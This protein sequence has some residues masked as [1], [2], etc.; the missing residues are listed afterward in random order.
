MSDRSSPRYVSYEALRE[1]E[2]DALMRAAPE[3]ME[4][5]LITYWADYPSG[6]RLCQGE[7][8]REPRAPLMEIGDLILC[9]V[10]FEL[11]FEPE[12]EGITFLADEYNDS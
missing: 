12:N 2:L 6:I 5:D 7:A 10:C 1:S 4:D 8:C 9:E 3:E 11:A